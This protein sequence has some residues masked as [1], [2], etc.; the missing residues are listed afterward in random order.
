[1]IQVQPRDN[2]IN[3]VTVVAFLVDNEHAIRKHKWNKQLKNSLWDIGGGV[4][5]NETGLQHSVG[6]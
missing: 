4:K 3:R 5:K 6:C 1:M 2:K